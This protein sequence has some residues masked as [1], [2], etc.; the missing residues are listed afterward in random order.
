MRS[1]LSNLL[2]TPVLH[3]LFIFPL[4]SEVAQASIIEVLIGD[5]SFA[6]ISIDLDNPLAATNIGGMVH[7]AG[8]H[9][10]QAARQLIDLAT[11]AV[12]QIDL[13][14]SL[15]SAPG[16]GESTEGQINGAALLPDGTVI[17]VGQSA[18]LL[19][20][21]QPTYWFDP[22]VPI[23]QFTSVGTSASG[24]LAAVS[25]NG[26]FVGISGG[27]GAP[28]Y[29]DPS[30]RNFSLLPGFTIAGI[31]DISHDSQYIVGGDLIWQMN[32]LGGYNVLSTSD[33]DFSGSGI[34]PS[35]I[36]V[37]IDPLVGDAVFAGSY[38]DLNTFSSRVGFWRSDGTFIGAT[39]DG[40][41][42]RDFEVWEGQLVA[43]VTDFDDS[44]LYAISDFSM[45]SLENILGA[46]SVIYENGLFVGSAGFLA[47]GTNGAFLTTHT[48]S[49]PNADQGGTEVPEPMTATLLGLGLLLLGKKRVIQ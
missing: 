8:Q 14:E 30:S 45:I 17:Y 48:T 24:L 20:V 35:F 25:D 13:F 15:L 11:G 1:T 21:D 28:A 16:L 42:F 19:S 23:E 38:F 12:H 18:G 31:R 34:M 49:D 3:L 9:E 39:I 46:K 10:G 26:T 33:F 5:V 37:A 7:V 43:A 41:T 6:P 2:I 29:G 4:C 36:G 44:F 40:T 32:D 27:G 47:S 22:K